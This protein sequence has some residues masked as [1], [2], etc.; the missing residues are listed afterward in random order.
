M[1][2][3]KSHLGSSQICPHLIDPAA[4][5]ADHVRL[6]TGRGMRYNVCCAVCDKALRAGKPVQLVDAW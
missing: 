5:N 3:G 2:L 1:V 4:G 6:L